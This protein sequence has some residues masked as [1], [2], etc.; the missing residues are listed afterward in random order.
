MVGCTRERQEMAGVAIREAIDLGV[1]FIDT[2]DVCAPLRANYRQGARGG[3]FV[4]NFR[5]PAK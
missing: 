3:A 4:I 5:L 1:N 2:V